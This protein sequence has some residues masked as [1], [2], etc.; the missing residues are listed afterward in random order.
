MIGNFPPWSLEL[1]TG[2]FPNST[3]SFVTNCRFSPII[4]INTTRLQ[5]SIAYIKRSGQGNFW[6]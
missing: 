2:Y 1:P 5:Y 4:D 3:G 6:A